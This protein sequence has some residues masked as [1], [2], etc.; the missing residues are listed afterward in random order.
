MSKENKSLPDFKALEAVIRSRQ[1]DTKEVDYSKGMPKKEDAGS[2]L[3]EMKETPKEKKEFTIKDKSDAWLYLQS[4]PIGIFEQVEESKQRASEYIRTKCVN[5]VSEYCL[6]NGLVCEEELTRLINSLND[7]EKAHVDGE[8]NSDSFRDTAIPELIFRNASKYI[9]DPADIEK[10]ISETT[11]RT[12]KVASII[13]NKVE[14]G[15]FIKDI[16]TALNFL[17]A[18]DIEQ[19]RE[20]KKRPE[21]GQKRQE[22]PVQ[23]DEQPVEINNKPQRPKTFF[24]EFMELDGALQE[25]DPE[26]V[27]DISE[28]IFKVRPRLLTQGYSNEQI[29]QII[30]VAIEKMKGKIADFDDISKILETKEDMIEE[31]IAILQDNEDDLGEILSEMDFLSRKMDEFC[32]TSLYSETEAK[33]Y[34][35]ERNRVT[36]DRFPEFDKVRDSIKIIWHSKLD[37]DTIAPFVVRVLNENQL[38]AYLDYVSQ[39]D[40]QIIPDIDYF[41]TVLESLKQKGYNS[42]KVIDAVY[43]EIPQIDSITTALARSKGGE[44]AKLEEVLFGRK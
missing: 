41:G 14:S 26:D 39:E 44:Y 1:G 15:I 13:E 11:E 28:L 20:M 9:K 30:S 16:I 23:A 32:Q 12:K 24:L 37:F 21:I 4:L 17:D 3:E 6:K 19:I 29:D 7:A 5:S 25:F 31:A 43:K 27:E 2:K 18:R 10:I 8:D 22:K 36:R 40:P 38:K 33:Q 34:K 42:S 35:F